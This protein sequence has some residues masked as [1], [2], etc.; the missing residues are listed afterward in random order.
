[1]IAMSLANQAK[2]LAKKMLRKDVRVL[3]VPVPKGDEFLGRKALVVGGTGGIGRAIASSLAIKGCAV[4]I[5]G[6]SRQSLDAALKTMSAEIIG[7][8]LDVKNV[9]TFGNILKDVSE[10]LGGLDT[11]VYSAGIHG[12]EDFGAVS[13]ETWDEVMAV[14]LKGA[15]FICQEAGNLMVGSGV[16]GHILIVGSAS[17][18]KPGWT[19]YE[20]SKRGVQSF[21]L[22]AA[23]RLIRHGVTVNCI[24]PGPVA[25]KMLG[26]QDKDN[27]G[28]S[29]NPSGRLATPAEIAELATYMVSDLGSLVVG[30]SFYIT[31]GSGTISNR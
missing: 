16:H 19:P 26:R 17:A 3:K 31:G 15:Y 11:V 14:N 6:S 9:T 27:L 8:E 7:V 12:G 2:A 18:L 20:I 10:R 4:A 22:G 23:D 28:W 25:T 21:V 24:A 29:A 5:T 30:D 13:E 1:M